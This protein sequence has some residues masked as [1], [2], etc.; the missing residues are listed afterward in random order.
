MTKQE[1]K[2]IK[3]LLSVNEIDSSFFN[4]DNR[5]AIIES[6]STMNI[7]EL[8]ILLDDSSTYGYKSKTVF[9]EDLDLTFTNLKNIGNTSLEVHKGSCRG[10]VC[11]IKNSIGL[12][13]VGN[14][15]R[16]SISLIFKENKN[17]F[18]DIFKCSKFELN[19][20]KVIVKPEIRLEDL[21]LTKEDFGDLPF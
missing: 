12:S 17:E 6:I 8:S 18:C 10:N 4:I 5:N 7:I 9:L 15:S 20:E 1:L 14:K 21:D 13:F 2:E 11:D 16:D 3:E 19:D